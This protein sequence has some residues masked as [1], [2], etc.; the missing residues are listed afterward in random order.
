MYDLSMKNNYVFSFC[1]DNECPTL[2]GPDRLFWSRHTLT[3][4]SGGHGA[5]GRMGVLF[6]ISVLTCCPYRLFRFLFSSRHSPIWKELA[7]RYRP[8]KKETFQV[9]TSV[10]L[11]RCLFLVPGALSRRGILT[12]LPGVLQTNSKWKKSS[13]R[14]R[15]ERWQ[16][17]GPFCCCVNHIEATQSSTRDFIG[18]DAQAD[19]FHQLYSVKLQ[20]KTTDNR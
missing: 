11:S 17:W 12:C 18:R 8:V 7:R 16:R 2:F 4:C 1:M 6:N 15:A 9:S 5:I 20:H 19:R 14:E 13:I 3:F 10:L